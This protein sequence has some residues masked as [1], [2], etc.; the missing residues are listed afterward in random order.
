M[1]KKRGN[2]LGM[3]KRE[4]SLGNPEISHVKFE[5]KEEM[6]RSNLGVIC[7]LWFKLV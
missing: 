6:S 7:T 2:H 3:R 4:S 5:I 1:T